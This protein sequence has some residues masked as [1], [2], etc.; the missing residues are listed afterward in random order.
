MAA[1]YLEEV[2]ADLPPADAEPDCIDA[3]RMD[4]T[5]ITGAEMDPGLFGAILVGVFGAIFGVTML[6]VTVWELVYR[7]RWST[8]AP[9]G[10]SGNEFSTGG[11]SQGASELIRRYHDSPFAG[12]VGVSWTV[13]QLLDRV[14]WPGLRQEVRTYLAS[15][16]VCLARK[17]PCPRRAPMEHVSLGHRWDRVAMD[18]LDMSVS[19]VSK[20]TAM[21]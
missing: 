19:T 4:E 14:Y 17:S 3:S 8:M 16:A 7:H 1:T 5:L 12:H 10:P 18:I 2:T 15:C 9:P 13:Y 21:Y 6:A 20:V 11:T